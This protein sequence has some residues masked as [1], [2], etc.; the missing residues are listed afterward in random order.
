VYKGPDWWVK[1]ADFGISK[2]ATEG[3]TAL[4]TQIGIPAFTAPEVFGAFQ[5]GPGSNDSYTNAVDIWS[6]GVI[7]FLIL[8]GEI[9]FNDKRPLRRYVSDDYEFPSDVLLKNKVSG[10]GCWF[11]KGL[12]AVKFQ[13]RPGAKEC[14]QHKWFESLI[15]DVAHETQRYCFLP[16]PQEHH[17]YVFVT[18]EI[19]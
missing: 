2:R 13:D 4:H 18:T 3:L 1:I 7:T 12:M 14:L 11:V 16:T 9:L 10:Y 19:Q 8:T 6:L 15:E 5:M 17:I